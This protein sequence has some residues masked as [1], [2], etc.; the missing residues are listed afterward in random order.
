M[1]IVIGKKEI[2]PMHMYE[3]GNETKHSEILYNKFPS[4]SR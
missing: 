2:Y 1:L 4:C 3:K